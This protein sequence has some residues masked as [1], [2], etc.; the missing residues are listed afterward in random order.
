MPVIDRHCCS[1]QEPRR[2]NRKTARQEL[3]PEKTSGNKYVYSP[4]YNLECVLAEH[5]K[6]TLRRL[7]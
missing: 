4:I 1:N 7:F 6:T 2:G 5:M 3:G